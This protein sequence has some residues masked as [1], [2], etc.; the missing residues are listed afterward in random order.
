MREIRLH[1]SEGGGA[2]TNRSFLPLSCSRPT[3]H[4]LRS[5]GPP[6]LPCAEPV[7]ALLTRQEVNMLQQFPAC[8]FRPE[9]T[10][11]LI[12]HFANSLR[13]MLSR[14]PYLTTWANG[15]ARHGTCSR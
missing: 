9:N 15:V 11:V 6:S 5:L 4:A 8:G 1:G 10:L 3:S 13:I 7:P 14:I 2:E 12:S